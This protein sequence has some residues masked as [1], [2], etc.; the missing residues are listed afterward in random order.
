LPP[1]E[2]QT[3]LARRG[4]PIAASSVRLRA[5]LHP[6]KNVFAVGRNYLDHAAEGARAQGRELKLPEAPAYFTKAPTTIADPGEVLEL[7][8]DVSSQY[9]WEA[10]LAIVIGTTCRDVG[11]A[12][13][14]SVVFGYT[15]LNDVTAR[16]LQ[17]LHLHPF[18]GKS[19]DHTCPLGPWIVDAAEA[20]NAQALD[21]ALRVNGVVKQHSNTANM[22]FSIVRIVSNLSQG[23][24]LEAGDV[25]ATGT[26]DG[27]GFARTPPE[28][29]RDGDVME[30]EIEKIGVLRNTVKIGPTAAL[31]PPRPR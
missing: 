24:T 12:D 16:D 10:E 2:R 26:P 19:L 15:A 13:A 23:L 21:I 3:A 31:T 7:S 28:F 11:E 6:R 30:V 25:I 18:K 17:R 27:V 22:I 14:L 1:E 8:S 29:L 4:A 5:P 9:D 20:G